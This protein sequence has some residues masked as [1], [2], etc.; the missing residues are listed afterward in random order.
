M[1][2]L[3]PE[4]IVVVVVVV[5][6]LPDPAVSTAQITGHVSTKA[7]R[8]FVYSV[9]GVCDLFMSMTQAVW[10]VCRLLGSA[11]SVI[12]IRT[13]NEHRLLLTCGD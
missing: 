5:V 9:T 12:Q 6:V 8:K 13:T 10:P 4:D 11:E 7:I 1:P 3:L 2:P